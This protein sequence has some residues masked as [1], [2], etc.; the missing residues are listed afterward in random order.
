[1]KRFIFPLTPIHLVC[2]FILGWLSYAFITGTRQFN[3]HWEE[4]GVI[5]FVCAVLVILEPFLRS[6]IDSKWWLWELVILV[7]V[8]VLGFLIIQGHVHTPR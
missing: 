8:L 2:V 1:M 3:I 5:I 7:T 4:W 6:S